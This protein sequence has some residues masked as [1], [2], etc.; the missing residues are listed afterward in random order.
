M[1]DITVRDTENNVFKLT[2]DK[3]YKIYICGPT[4]YTNTHVGHLKT[5]MTFD[6]IRRVIEDYFG[7]VTVLMMNIT[8]VDDKIIKA[9]YE[10]EYGEDIDLNNLLPD[11][12]LLTEKFEEFA[13]FWEK[14]FFAVMDKMGIKRPNVVSRV[15]EYID[16]IIEFVTAIDDKGFAFEHDGSVYFYGTKYADIKDNNEYSKD[17]ADPNNFVLLKKAKSYEPG[18]KTKWGTIRPGWHIECSA[19]ASSVFGSKI[20][21]HAG[22]IDLKFPHHHNE[23]VQSNCRYGYNK[24]ESE[25]WVDHFMHTGH[26]NI[27][28]LKMSRSLKNFITVEELAQIHTPDQLRMLFLL[29]DWD[30]PMDYSDDTMQHAVKYVDLFTNFFVQINSILLRSDVEEN[31]KYCDFE[32]ELSK[33]FNLLTTEINSHLSNNINTRSVIETLQNLTSL[34]FKYVTSAEGSKI[35]LSKEIIVDIKNYIQ[36]MLKIFGLSIGETESNNNNEKQLIKII[37]DVRTELRLT[38]K[39]ISI[40]QKSKTDTNLSSEIKELYDLSDKIR[41]KMLPE[42]GVVLTDGT[43]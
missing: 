27:K 20:D 38:A 39:K 22:G 30:E 28:G 9:T 24:T 42:I 32:K 33:E 12:Y 36:K 34:I 18:W 43:N 10:K 11:K 40:K 13:N 8:N 26:L 3:V 14:D 25:Q 23:M 41:D 37:S 1:T 31:K 15:T 2:R 7:V 19:M 35:K 5:Y 16:E 21:I 17:P 29:H 4:V 6:I